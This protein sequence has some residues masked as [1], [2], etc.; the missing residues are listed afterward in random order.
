MS[1]RQT[2]S[3][4]ARRNRRMRT[5]G[6]AFALTAA[7]TVGGIATAVPAGAATLTYVTVS[8]LGDG[9]HAWSETWGTA[10]DRCKAADSRTKSIHLDSVGT[11]WTDTPREQ[12]YTAVWAC[13]D[14]A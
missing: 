14:T 10:W 4:N 7:V 3:P 5:A 11:G 1:K 12:F 6:A 8:R 2:T 9:S 13:R